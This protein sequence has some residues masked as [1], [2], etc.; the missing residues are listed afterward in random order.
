MLR[1]A[2]GS[3]S[4]SVGQYVVLLATSFALGDGEA[5]TLTLGLKS[6]AQ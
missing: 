2:S 3:S 6:T 4:C 1:T 5:K